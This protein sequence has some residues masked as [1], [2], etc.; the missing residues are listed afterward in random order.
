M[1]LH[2]DAIKLPLS[3]ADLNHLAAFSNI[4]AMSTGLLYAVTDRQDEAAYMP[5]TLFPSPVPRV[6]YQKA[7]YMQTGFNELM[8]RVTK[9][10]EFL[11][12]AL[13]STIEA[14]EFTGR[15]FKIYKQVQ[16]EGCHK[17]V[18]LAVVR[19]DYLLHFQPNKP[20]GLMQVEINTNSISL[21]AMSVRTTQLHRAV[22]QEHGIPNNSQ[23][24]PDNPCTDGMCEGLVKAWELYGQP[25]AS[26]LF[27]VED[28]EKNI[29]DITYFIYQIKE[30][31]H[32]IKVLTRNLLYLG[33]NA[34][35]TDDRK[36]IVD[37]ME[38][39][40][41]YYR[42][43]GDPSHFT[44]EMEWKFKLIAEQS[45]AAVCPSI[46]WHLADTKK[47]QQELSQPRAV[48]RYLSDPE[49]ISNMRSTFAA[50]YSLDL[51]AEGDKAAAMG[52]ANPQN[53]VMKPQREGGGNNIYGDDIRVKLE[54]L[55]GQQER[56]G[57]IL[58]ERIMPTV[59][60]NYE[61][62]RGKPVDMQDMV[63]ELGIY[64]VLVCKEDQVA[65]NKASGHLLRTKN[66][67]NNEGGIGAG[68][69]A[70]DSPYLV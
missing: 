45:L 4:R 21:A 60:K 55:A 62:C 2:N 68:A 56:S 36:L 47:I 31:N 12:S 8:W 42:T 7:V 17:P 40:I 51:T 54:E 37:G 39:A 44:S 63:S 11:T 22:L 26:I 20:P 34:Q 27:V 61:L 1:S 25:N 70:M 18:T 46:S 10:D 52:I 14:D 9:D 49:M 57:Y 41:V 59:V 38:V 53:Y 67:M 29:F 48:E 69:S 58:M 19:P 43:G 50:Q 65:I 35:L 15:L 13:K 66:V 28:G 64:G 3:D 16:E 30:L 6:L 5:H 32:A 24:V 33:K 23:Q